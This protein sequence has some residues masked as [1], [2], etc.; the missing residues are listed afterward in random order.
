VGE[1]LKVLPDDTT[2]LVVSDH[3]VQDMAGGICINQWLLDNGWLALEG[4]APTEPT[5]LSKLSVDWSRTRAW[6]EG[7][8]Y[9]RVFLNVKGREP[10]GT[11]EQAD[12]EAVRAELTEGLAAIPDAEGKRLATRVL[13]PDEIYAGTAGIA[14]DLMVYFGDLAWRSI[15]TVGHAAHAVLENDTGADDANHHPDG[16]FVVA[17]PG[18]PT[19]G[20]ALEGLT[21]YDVA[22]TI[23]RLLDQDV[24]ADML[25]RVVV[26]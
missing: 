12:Y 22:P 18:A 5:S 20:K 13:R 17:G 21:L 7:G 3:G 23:L 19:G 10:Q 15:G 8:Y 2:V 14:P 1:L 11:V 4:A 25:G 6:A 9:G 26:G 16:V 24:P